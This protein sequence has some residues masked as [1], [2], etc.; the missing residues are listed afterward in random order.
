VKDRVHLPLFLLAFTIA[1]VLKLAVVTDEELATRWIDCQI[2]YRQP[3]AN[4]VF[5]DQ[6][7]KVRVEIR[8]QPSELMQLSPFT[9]GVIVTVPRDR[10]GNV[11]VTLGENNVEFR[12]FGD[13]EVVGMVPDHFSMRIEPRAVET[14]PVRAELV[15]EPAAGSQPGDVAVRPAWVEIS[16]PE[17]KVRAIVQVTARVS[18]DGH[19]RTFEDT[20]LLESPDPVV[21]VQPRRVVVEVTMQEPEL[22]LSEIDGVEA[23]DDEDESS[24]S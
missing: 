20:V 13:F 14:V 5:Y 10:L 11:G 2:T 7:D 9:V 1:L 19:A 6:L 17:S 23:N 21:Q 22:I 3:D 18:L 15:G 8:G 16:G 24:T 12:A 4:L